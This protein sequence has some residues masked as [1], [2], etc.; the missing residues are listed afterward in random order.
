MIESKREVIGGATSVERRYF[1]SSLG[2][3]E[4]ELLRTV[5]GHWAI[6][7]QLHWC[8]D[9]SFR[10]VECRVREENAAENLAIIRYLGINLLKQERSSK[11]S[12]KGKRLKAGWDDGYLIKVLQF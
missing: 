1:I 8:S 7:N 6:E 5:R 3:N 11:R 4:V 9:I 10:E 12:S 2:A